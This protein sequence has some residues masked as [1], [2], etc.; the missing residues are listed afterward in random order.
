MLGDCQGTNFGAVRNLSTYW[1]LLHWWEILFSMLSIHLKHYYGVSQ[2][3]FLLNQVT[4]VITFTILILK[5]AQ[6]SSSVWALLP[7]QKY[8]SNLIRMFP[9]LINHP[10]VDS[11]IIIVTLPSGRI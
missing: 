6:N 9:V 5:N 4:F 11:A 3:L 10:N 2:L 7:S 8:D 1:I